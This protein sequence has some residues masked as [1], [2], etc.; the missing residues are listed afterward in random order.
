MVAVSD[1]QAEQHCAEQ[2]KR[3]F[4]NEKSRRS[5]YLQDR[6]KG[7][8]MSNEKPPFLRLIGWIKGKVRTVDPLIHTF[9]ARKHTTASGDES[10][11]AKVCSM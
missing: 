2:T 10:E 9:D 1:F 5:R 7:H 8:F 6:V 11:R 3:S 4:E